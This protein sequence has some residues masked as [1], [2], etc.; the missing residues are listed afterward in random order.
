MDR[1]VHKSYRIN[2]DSTCPIQNSKSLPDQMSKKSHFNFFAI[3]EEMLS[4]YTF[5]KIF[6]T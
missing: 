4:S 5:M 6:T 2:F 1:P 3:I